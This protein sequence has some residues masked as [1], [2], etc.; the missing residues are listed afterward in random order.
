M[1]LIGPEDEVPKSDKLWSSNEKSQRYLSMRYN[2]AT[3]VTTFFIIHAL[4]NT[5]IIL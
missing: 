1:Q 3:L 4:F 5:K 2:C